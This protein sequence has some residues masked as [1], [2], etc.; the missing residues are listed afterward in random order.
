MLGL[1]KAF[2]VTRLASLPTGVPMTNPIRKIPNLNIPM[3]KQDAAE[4]LE[5]RGK[6]ERETQTRLPLAE[7]ARIAIRELNKAKAMATA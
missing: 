1:R 6:L 2:F 3:T 5:L 4:L 7:V